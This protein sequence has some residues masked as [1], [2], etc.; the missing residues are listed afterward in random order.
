MIF[1]VRATIRTTLSNVGIDAMS[2]SFL[3]AAW[4]LFCF[5]A[6]LCATAMTSYGQ[7]ADRTA[8][9]KYTW[10]EEA[11]SPRA[12]DWVKT[13]DARSA[14]V[15]RT[16]KNFAPFQAQALAI[17]EDEHRLSY[18][19][20]I[21]GQVYNFWHDAAHIRGILRVTTAAEYVTAAPHWRTL[22]DV[23]TLNLKEHASWVYKG[24]H[25][26]QPE[27]RY[28]LIR[29]SAGGEDADT[30]REFDLQQGTFVAEGF[31]LPRSPGWVAWIDRDTVLA[32]R[33]WGSGT[34]AK[35]GYPFV[36]KE[37]KRG[38]P[39]SAAHEVY[40]G[41][42]EQNG[43]YPHVLHDSQGHVLQCIDDNLAF[44]AN[45]IYVRTASG[46]QALGMPLHTDVSGLLDGQILV[47]LH[48]AWSPITGGP[49]LPAGSIFS[50]DLNET[51]RD[52]THLRPTLVYA[53]THEEFLTGLET[54][55]SHLVVTTL[56]QVRGGAYTYTHSKAGWSRTTLLPRADVTVA[57]ESGDDSS[58][59][60]AMYTSG[61]LVPPNILIGPAGGTASMHVA[62]SGPTLFDTSQLVVDQLSAKSKDGT[63]IP[64]FVVHRRNMSYTGINPT[65]LYA[66][67]GFESAITPFYDATMG[68]LWLD[69]GGVFVVA[70]IRG[71]GEFG[72]AWHEQTLKTNRQRIYDDFAAVGQD[73][74]RRKI[75]TPAH[76]GIK[77]ASAGGLLMG[78]EMVQH[79]TFWNAVVIQVPLLDMLNY[80]HIAEGLSWT[81]EY[82]SIDVPEERAFLQATSPY[83]NL[84]PG[85]R[86]P[87]PLLLTSTKDDR[88][89]P[90]HAR[91]FAAKL[92]EY[93]DPFLFD[94][95]SEGGH[96]SGADGK[97]AAKTQAEVYVYL[98][99]KLMSHMD[100]ANGR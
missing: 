7:V 39:L 48:E 40:R 52:P 12:L 80:Q 17:L 10:L 8:E 70:N 46:F 3:R 95:Y 58:D 26:L 63:L 1:P 71:G 91:K 35:S 69:R 81:A 9:D 59:T 38:T 34:V 50:V 83:E 56:N 75:T 6:T 27:D 72:P 54:T 41:K 82:G 86:Y 94:E 47:R 57:V 76:L 74:V 53:P 18:P 4:P 99:R 14:A 43:T 87:E 88:V 61:F 15:L 77:G 45:V 92:E 42:P 23:D 73:L 19:D 85:I 21:G 51:L 98:T 36:V 55:S 44:F 13:E 31:Q 100:N 22:L 16:D 25:V 32:A 49:R 60:I 20:L 11:T 67:G 90:Q 33:D 5:V 64:Y 37:W 28:A 2:R 78:V 93:R 84:R 24:M 96:S 79:P 97:Q 68:R 66:Y 65:V 29:L 89:G 62:Q 30:I